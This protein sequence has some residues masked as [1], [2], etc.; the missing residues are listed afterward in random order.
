MLARV[1]E[2]SQEIK[3][4]QAGRAWTKKLRISAYNKAGGGNNITG[5]YAIKADMLP[6]RRYIRDR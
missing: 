1:R 4:K 6:Y 3:I 5:W 2:R